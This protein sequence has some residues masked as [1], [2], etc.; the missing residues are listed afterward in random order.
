MGKESREK[1]TGKTK[2]DRVNTPKG[3]K[4]IR[5]KTHIPKVNEACGHSPNLI[6]NG[7]ALINR[8]IEDKR[9]LEG[10]E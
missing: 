4:D 10:K 8:L 9:L 1:M 5:G 3:N 2:E 7:E 6:V